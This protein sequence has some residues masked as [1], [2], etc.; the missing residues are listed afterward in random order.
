MLWRARPFLFCFLFV[1]S[2]SSRGANLL[3][4]LR[5]F[6]GSGPLVGLWYTGLGADVVHIKIDLSLWF[7]IDLSVL[8]LV[9]RDAELVRTRLG[10]PRTLIP[11]RYCY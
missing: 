3:G 2:D 9:L 5:F 8:G 6:G 11:P 4:L 10:P 7:S 1:L